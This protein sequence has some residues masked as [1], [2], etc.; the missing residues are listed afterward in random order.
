MFGTDAPGP[1]AD[2]A[3]RPEPPVSRG[4]T[5]TFGVCIFRNSAPQWTQYEVPSS[6]RVPQ[7]EQNTRSAPPSKRSQ[8]PA[9]GVRPL[10]GIPDRPNS[11]PTEP[12]TA[13][14]SGAPGG[15]PPEEFPL[16]EPYIMPPMPPA[17][18]AGASS[19]GSAMITSVVTISEPM[20][21]AFCNALLVTM[22]GSMT[23]ACTRSSY[24]PVRAL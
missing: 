24:S 9:R 1:V 13:R 20:E 23:P 19:S 5:S 15:A 4:G 17:G 10:C 2:P 16:G 3:E 22:A 12:R 7:F 18:M 14:K 21:A 11:A 6:F 8:L